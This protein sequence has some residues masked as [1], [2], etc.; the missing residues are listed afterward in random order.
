MSRLYG[1]SINAITRNQ[2]VRSSIPRLA[3]QLP[4]SQGKVMQ[5]IT[6]FADNKKSQLCTKIKKPWMSGPVLPTRGT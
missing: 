4:K 6:D 3:L 5:L 1:M 2:F